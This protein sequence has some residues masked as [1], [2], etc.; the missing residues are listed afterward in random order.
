[1]VGE[2]GGRGANLEALLTKVIS[3]KLALV[4]LPVDYSVLFLKVNHVNQGLPYKEKMQVVAM[5]ATVGNLKELS[6]FLDAELFTENF[7]PVKLVEH[8]VV[9]NDICEVRGTGASVV[10]E[11]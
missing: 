4:F 2:K 7:R 3:Y 5:S 10:E 9:G 8:V 6:T 1:M 11:R